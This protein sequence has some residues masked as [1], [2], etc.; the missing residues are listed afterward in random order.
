MQLLFTLTH[1]LFLSR[2]DDVMSCMHPPTG[3]PQS[4]SYRVLLASPGGMPIYTGVTMIKRGLHEE[5]FNCSLF[6][7]S[8]SSSAERSPLFYGVASARAAV[9]DVTIG[10]EE[11]QHTSQPHVIRRLRAFFCGKPIQ[12]NSACHHYFTAPP[13]SS[14]VNLPSITGALGELQTLPHG[15]MEEME[16][17][18][19]EKAEVPSSCG[20]SAPESTTSTILQGNEGEKIDAPQNILAYVSGISNETKQRDGGTLGVLADL[21]SVN[22][23]DNCP[24]RNRGGRWRDGSW[25][26]LEHGQQAPCE[27]GGRYRPLRRPFFRRC[28][29]SSRPWFRYHRGRNASFDYQPPFYRSRREYCF[30]TPYFDR[31][32]PYQ[33]RP[34]HGHHPLLPQSEDRLRVPDSRMPA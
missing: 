30:K 18:E 22:F 11:N 15:E 27:G 21:P 20:S 25:P 14:P 5:F 32:S 33:G 16:H 31:D 8:M 10:N 6:I 26:A 2:G 9:D 24:R 13:S 23:G 29:A 4:G 1:V 17:V 12:F 7:P 3:M 28:V 34:A 19:V